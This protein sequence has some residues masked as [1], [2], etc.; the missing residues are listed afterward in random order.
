MEDIDLAYCISIHK[1]Q[2]SEFQNVV[3]SLPGVRTLSRNLLYTAVTRAKE[4][5]VIE[6]EYGAVFKAIQ[7]SNFGRRY[8]Y[9]PKRMATRISE[10]A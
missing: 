3:L 8:S 6:S 4:K 1:S 7:A 2:G 5:V 9:L 10:C